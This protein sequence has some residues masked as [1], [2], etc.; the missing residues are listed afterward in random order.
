M[1]FNTVLDISE[2]EIVS[3]LQSVIAH[4]KKSAPRDDDTMQVDSNTSNVPSLSTFLSSCVSYTTSPATLRLAIRNYLPDAEDICCVLE[5]LDEWIIKWNAMTLKLLP[6]NVSKNP[7][8]VMVAKLHQAK[9]ADGPLLGN[10]SSLQSRICA[11]PLNLSSQGYIV[12]TNASRRII[13]HTSAVRSCSR[14]SPSDI[15]GSRARAQPCRSNGTAPWS[16]R[17]IC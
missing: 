13:S 15:L 10:V 2:A 6:K 11:S 1:A 12:P 17:T 3:I 9:R 7:R 4:H 14:S 8:G 5:V 16:S